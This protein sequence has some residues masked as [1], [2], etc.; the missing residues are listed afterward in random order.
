MEL[1]EIDDNEV[2]YRVV[3]VSYP[4]AFI[5]GKPTAA[6]FMDSCGVS[7]DRDGG[8]E[9]KEIISVLK[10]RFARLMD[11][12]TSVKISVAECRE[13]DTCPKPIG[14]KKN[15]YHAEIHNSEDV[16]PIDLLKALQLANRCC[17]VLE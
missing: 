5:N 14:N 12:K 7:V 2:L 4:N 17:V 10:Q 13:I 8:R 1:N 11:Y 15:K 3:R 16:V 6:L 9:E